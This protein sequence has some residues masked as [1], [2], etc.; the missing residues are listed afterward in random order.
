MVSVARFGVAALVMTGLVLGCAPMASASP[1]Y[2]EPFID[3]FGPRI[4]VDLRTEGSGQR[5]FW[6]IHSHYLAELGNKMTY[7]EIQLAMGSSVARYCEEYV[8]DYV[9]YLSVYNH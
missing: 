4:C 6:A 7:E 2:F 3:K 5:T 8:N 1:E 9:Y